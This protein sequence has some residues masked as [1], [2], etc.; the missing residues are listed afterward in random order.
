MKDA[1]QERL[2][3][4]LEKLI[5]HHQKLSI[6]SDEFKHSL[7]LMDSYLGL[8]PM[9]E[10]CGNAPC[11]ISNP[12]LLTK[13]INVLTRASKIGFDEETLKQWPEG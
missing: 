5:R 10:K 2:P 4:I 6:G 7:S 11:V 8:F 3:Q 12:L 9:N 13:F 1:A